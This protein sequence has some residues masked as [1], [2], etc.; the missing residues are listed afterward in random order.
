MTQRELWKIGFGV[1]LVGN[2][3]LT[4]AEFKEFQKYFAIGDG[5]QLQLLADKLN[6]KRG[7]D[8]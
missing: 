5:A 4:D 8:G 1:Y 2:D 6:E 7:W 3:D